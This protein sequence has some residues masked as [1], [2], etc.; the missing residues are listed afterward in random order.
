MAGNK[1]KNAL[2][3]NP[4]GRI[5]DAGLGFL[6]VTKKIFT[7]AA[8]GIMDV[9]KMVKN[10]WLDLSAELVNAMSSFMP[11]R[12]AYAPQLVSTLQWRAK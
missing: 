2:N 7:N 1:I 3:V 5:K 6:N 4:I 9:M 12:K 8:G 11:R 10:R